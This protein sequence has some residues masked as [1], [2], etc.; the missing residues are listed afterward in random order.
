MRS[1]GYLGEFERLVLLAAL[2]LR[3]Q[4]SGP[5]RKGL[6]QVSRAFEASCPSGVGKR[7]GSP[8]KPEGKE[9]LAEGMRQLESMAQRQGSAGV[10]SEGMDSKLGREALAS[11]EAGLVGIYG[12]NERTEDVLR[13]LQEELKRPKI[14]L[15]I[16]IVESLLR[17]IQPLRREVAPGTTPA[18]K[19]AKQTYI[20]PSRLPPAYRK[21]IEKYFQ[22]LSEQR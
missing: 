14:V 10:Q 3:R 9:A 4:A 1:K 12:Y 13:K 6:Q 18:P 2:R 7:R 21:S 15:D 16:R 8:L 22:K 19:E 20:D 11:I 5:L 17:Q